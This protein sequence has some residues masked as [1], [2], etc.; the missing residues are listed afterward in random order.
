MPDEGHPKDETSG[1][2]SIRRRLV[3]AS[4]PLVEAAR[5]LLD[6]PVDELG[7]IDLGD[8]LVV[9]PGARAGRQ[10]LLELEEIA[11]AR[12]TRAVP[13]RVLT[14]AGLP[15]A[16]GTS[17]AVPAEPETWLAAVTASLEPSPDAGD[18]ATDLSSLCGPDAGAA[19]RRAAGAERVV[20]GVQLGER[21]AAREACA[22]RLRLALGGGGAREDPAEDRGDGAAEAVPDA[23]DRWAGGRAIVVE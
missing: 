18:A 10:F 13:P 6:R 17:T 2:A 4:S 21:R 9:L 19:E 22:E 12:G 20:A 15:A 1:S 7:E 23:M 3:G 14:P 5:N 16:I 11:E 8:V